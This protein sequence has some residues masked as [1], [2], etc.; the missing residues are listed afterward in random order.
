MARNPEKDAVE[1]AAKR[2]NILKAGFRL[3]SDKGIESVTMNDVAKEAGVGVATLYRYYATKPEL[4]LGVCTA[5]WTE[6]LGEALRL[7]DP[8]QTPGFTAAHRLRFYLDVFIDLYRNH[9]DMLRFNQFFNIYLRTEPSAFR[10]DEFNGMV[11]SLKTRFHQLYELGMRDGTL[12]KDISEDILFSSTIHIML[13]AVTRY[14]VGL[15]YMPE[16]GADPESELILLR[17]LFLDRFTA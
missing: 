1:M 2:E 9:K 11:G 15:A 10:M 17:D 16:D 8:A 3:F 13:A 14:A 5:S 4:V 6:Y 7:S 12:R